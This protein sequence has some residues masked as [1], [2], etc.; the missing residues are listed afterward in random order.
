MGGVFFRRPFHAEVEVINDVSKDVTTFLK[1]LQRH[2]VEFVNF[3]RCLDVSN[4]VSSYSATASAANSVGISSSTDVGTMAIWAGCS[5]PSVAPFHVSRAGFATINKG[6]ISCFTIT[7]GFEYDLLPSGSICCM[8]CFK[9]DGIVLRRECN[10]AI[11]GASIYIT[12][13]ASGSTAPFAPMRIVMASYSC[14]AICTYGYINVSGTTYTSDRNLKCDFDLNV[15]ILPSLRKMPLGDWKFKGSDDCRI[16]AIAQD[17][18]CYFQKYSQNDKT[19]PNMEGLALKGVQELDIFVQKH[20]SKV[21]THDKCISML[22]QKLQ[23]LECE[24]AAIRE[25]IN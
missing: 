14:Y 1:V 7:E 20:E 12:H 22:K 25:M 21:E 23:K 11:V 3:M 19:V 8:T 17:F 9:P 24:M 6:N 5:T 10:A 15:S 16:G 18:S 2:F 4:H 13:E